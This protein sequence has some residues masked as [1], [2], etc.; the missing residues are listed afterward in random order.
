TPAS[1]LTTGRVITSKP[2]SRS[3]WRK[4]TGGS[5]GNSPPAPLQIVDVFCHF[6]VFLFVIGFDVQH[7][8]YRGRTIQVG[9]LRVDG[10]AQFGQ[11]FQR[12]G[13]QHIVVR[14]E[15]HHPFWLHDL[16]VL[17]Q[18]GRVGKPLLFSAFLRLGVG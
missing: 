15:V 12:I 8:V 7:L 3:M 18:K 10:Q 14:F 4:S 9:G 11:F 1:D 6:E 13:V 2:H 17:F 16:F 5:V